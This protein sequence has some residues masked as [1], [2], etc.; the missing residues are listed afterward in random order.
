MGE[1]LLN[2]ENLIKSIDLITNDRG[3]GMSPKRITVS[4]A[5]ISKM[6]K[7]LA[8]DDVKFNLA[9]SLHTANNEKRNNIMPI[10]ESIDLTK[11]EEAIKYFYEKTGTRVTYEYILFDGV[12][13]TIE[14]AKQLVNFCKKAP[15]KVNL[16]EYNQVDGF[17]FKKS[18]NKK[19]NNFIEYLEERN[20]IVN[21]RK[22]KG[23]DINA[24][25]GQLV[26]KLK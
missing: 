3:L 11:L 24:A 26:N 12:N 13:D 8:D 10:N 4:T 16:I 2:Y 25:C 22:S 21:L 19:T 14:D 5:G 23:K 6:I 9:L 20:V 1:P 17:P 7:K 18:S 15:C